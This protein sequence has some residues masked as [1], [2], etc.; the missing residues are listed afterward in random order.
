MPK[1]QISDF[2]E[3]FLFSKTSGLDHLIQYQYQYRSTM[4]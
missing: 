2:K 4:F 3:Y 1:L